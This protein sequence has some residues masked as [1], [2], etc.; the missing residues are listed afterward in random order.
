MTG[1]PLL[2]MVA[3]MANNAGDMGRCGRG[4]L[5]V[6]LWVAPAAAPGRTELEKPR[7]GS[8]TRGF[9]IGACLQM[10]LESHMPIKGRLLF[11]LFA[12]WTRSTGCA[13]AYGNVV[14]CSWGVLRSWGVEAVRT[15]SLV[16]SATEADQGLK[17]QSASTLATI[18][19]GPE[20][21][22]YSVVFVGQI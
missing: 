2:C 22:W 8:R 7:R 9:G 18:T 14:L 12:T 5:W 1:L 19:Q 13:E 10:H 16:A 6:V 4:L 17:S 21:R 11:P 20:G 3:S 15:A